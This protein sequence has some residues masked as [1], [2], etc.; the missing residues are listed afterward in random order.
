MPVVLFFTI[1]VCLKDDKDHVYGNRGTLTAETEKR[2]PGNV[3]KYPVVQGY[4]GKCKPL[5]YAFY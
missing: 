1:I 4:G 5:I 3:R 2:K